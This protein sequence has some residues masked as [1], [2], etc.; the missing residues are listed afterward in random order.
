MKPRGLPRGG[1]FTFL[2]LASFANSAGELFGVGLLN[3]FMIHGWVPLQSVYFSFNA[4]AWS[5]STEFFFYLCFPILIQNWE[6]TWALKLLLTFAV[7]SSAVLWANWMQ[8][9]GYSGEG[10]GLTTHGLLYIS[11]VAR[12]FEFVLG[13][14]SIQLWRR[15]QRF[16]KGKPL[17]ATSLEIAVLILTIAW[18]LKQPVIIAIGSIVGRSGRDY[19]V[20][21]GSAFA[22]ALLIPVMAMERGF[23]S[24]ILSARAFVL[25]GEISFSIYLLHQ[26][27]LRCIGSRF[28]L[29]L[30]N[31]SPMGLSSLWVAIILIAYFVWRYIEIPC[32]NFLL[33]KWDGKKIEN[34]QLSSGDEPL[35]T[36]A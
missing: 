29:I 18:L 27:I 11:P 25:L 33:R 31:L 34:S 16:Q 19:F 21:C 7:L 23:I 3:L 5:I 24:K 36:A 17:F 20:H 14:S 30:S 15:L 12:L 10:K 2:P 28:P 4:V 13:M 9:P 26:V 1:S 22:F 32:R 6:R 8:L 35:K